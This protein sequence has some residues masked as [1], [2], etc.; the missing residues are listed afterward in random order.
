MVNSKSIDIFKSPAFD[1][2]TKQN[3]ITYQCATLTYDLSYELL[4][5]MG[6]HYYKVH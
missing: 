6:C 5:R 2:Q 4:L 1:Y 3:Q